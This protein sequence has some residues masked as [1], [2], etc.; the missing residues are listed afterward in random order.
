MILLKIHSFIFF[1]VNT[2]PRTTTTATQ[3]K[4]EKVY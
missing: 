4:K 1:N 2:T 3:N